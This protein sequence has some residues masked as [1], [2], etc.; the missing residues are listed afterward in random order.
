MSLKVIWINNYVNNSQH[1]FYFF[2]SENLSVVA[3]TIT[4]IM[5]RRTCSYISSITRIQI[6]IRKVIFFSS[7]MIF[8][9]W[10]HDETCQTGNKV[11]NYV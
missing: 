5:W 2:A 11:D 8:G 3:S 4:D 6:C 9:D 1:L 10:L 7:K